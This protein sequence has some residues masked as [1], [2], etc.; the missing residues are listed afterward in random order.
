MYCSI[1]SA[2][3]W[4][5]LFLCIPLYFLACNTPEN[6]PNL[7]VPPAPTSGFLL[8]GTAESLEEPSRAEMG[9]PQYRQAREVAQLLARKQILEWLGSEGV[10]LSELPLVSPGIQGKKGNLLVLCM[11][12]SAGQLQQALQEK[13]I[14]QAETLAKKVGKGIQSWA[15]APLAP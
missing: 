10:S 8:L 3:V 7:N 4:R 12:I 6:P 11:E 13:N 2:L 14:P 1:S 9:T 15:S 5:F